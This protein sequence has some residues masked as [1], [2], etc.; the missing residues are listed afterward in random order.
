MTPKYAP[1]ITSN[2]ER[3]ETSLQAAKELA[4]KNYHDSAVSRAY[5][6]CFYAATALL[7]SADLEFSKHS[8]VISTI[9]QKY[10]KTGKLDKKHGKSLNWLFELRSIADY[11]VLIHV[12]QQDAEDAIKATEC[13]LSAIKSLIF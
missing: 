10:V 2:L 3:A 7:L 9:H 8:G 1:E 5:Y 11:G 12:S 6:V 13:F 4:L